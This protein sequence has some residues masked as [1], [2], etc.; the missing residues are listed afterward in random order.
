[1]LCVGVWDREERVYWSRNKRNNRKMGLVEVDSGGWQN[2][3]YYG[4]FFGF[5]ELRGDFECFGNDFC[6][7]I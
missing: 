3:Q 7:R 2:F 5:W 4:E 1:M 6:D